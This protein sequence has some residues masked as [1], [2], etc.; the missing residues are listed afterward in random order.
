MVEWVG[1]HIPFDIG[2]GQTCFLNQVKLPVSLKLN[3]S[4][5]Q[6]YSYSTILP[7]FGHVQF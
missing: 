2:S 1:E 3:I 6:N 4:K 5:K 7:P